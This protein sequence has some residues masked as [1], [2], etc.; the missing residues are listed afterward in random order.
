MLYSGVD[1]FPR[2]SRI[3]PSRKMNFGFA[4]NFHWIF[5][6]NLQSVTA[7]MFSMVCHMLFLSN[8]FFVRIKRDPLVLV[9]R[10]SRS[11]GTGGS[12]F[13]RICLIRN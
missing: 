3:I 12:R 2:G 10:A 4:Y 13:V 9:E 7:E 6:Q 1:L 11:D 5:E 8:L